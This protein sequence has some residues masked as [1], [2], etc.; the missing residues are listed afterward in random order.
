MSS[1]IKEGYVKPGYFVGDTSFEGVCA[2][3]TPSTD[4]GT[5][6]ILTTLSGVEVCTNP[7]TGSQTVSVQLT[8]AGQPADAITITDLATISLQLNVSGLSVSA[9]TLTEQLMLA[10]ETTLIGDSAVCELQAVAGLISVSVNVAGMSGVS[11]TTYNA[12][13]GSILLRTLISGIAPY[14]L[15]LTDGVISLHSNQGR[16]CV[17]Y[18]SS[19]LLLCACTAETS[20]ELVVLN[21]TVDR[22][23]SVLTSL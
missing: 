10:V 3:S 19:E 8:L 14:C 11:S 23:M 22:P 12:Y 2:I 1:Y 18:L 15:L 21:V 9:E 4:V 6:T 7:V 17:Y 16:C 13:L 20:P 5:L